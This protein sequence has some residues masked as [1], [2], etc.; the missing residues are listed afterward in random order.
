MKKILIDPQK[1]SGCRY[2]ELACVFNKE[3]TLQ[4]SLA[5]IQVFY[6]WDEGLSVPIVCYHCED[7]PCIN[8]CPTGALNRNEHDAVVVDY[9]KCLGCRV[10]T[11]ACPFGAITY[12]T[13]KSKILKC[14]LCSGDPVCVKF[15]STGAIKYDEPDKLAVQ[16]KKTVANNVLAAVLSETIKQEVE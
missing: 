11:I 8:A 9:E 5:R 16:K 4:P 13:E 12:S 6:N 15:C 1:C 14:D 2:C 7:A 10:C 3:K